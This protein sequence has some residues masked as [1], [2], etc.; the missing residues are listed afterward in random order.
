[1]QLT[2][3]T[4]DLPQ[5]GDVPAW[6]PAPDDVHTLR[7][8]Y[9]LADLDRLTRMALTRIIGGTLDHRTRYETAWSAIAETLYA[10][11]QPP[12]PS[13]LIHA[14]QRELARHAYQEMRQHGHDH[15]N[16][17]QTMRRYAAY[18]WNPPAGDPLEDVVVDRT[19]LWQIWPRLTDRERQ[20]LL[21]L[22]ATGDYAEAAAALD[23][24]PSTFIVNV[25]RARR[26]FFAFWH[27]G[28]TP[29]GAWGTDRRVGARARTGTLPGKGNRQ[30]VTRLVKKRKGRPRQQPVHGRVST[31]TNHGCRC[32]P[33]TRAQA[34][35]AAARRRAKG[36]SPR[37]RITADQLEQIRQRRA[38]G[39][40][41]RAI[42]AEL[43]FTDS[44]LYRLLSGARRPA[45][46]DR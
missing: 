41:V 3:H 36:V 38:A 5:A 30:P 16:A 46:S 7:H 2:Y 34:E 35:A 14:A 19:A 20:V 15:H 21:A 17:G 9:N 29:R 1:M 23:A 18:W 32:E 45:P 8:G 22:A 44:Y 4:T 10:S 6:Q 37:R 28:E 31:Y 25:R 13:E 11:D 42:A 43:G 39:E 12:T 26:R 40:S 33:C 24:N 27:E